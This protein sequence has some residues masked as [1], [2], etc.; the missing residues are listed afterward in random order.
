[1]VRA[2]RRAGMRG[3]VSARRVFEAAQAG[4]ERAAAVVAVEAELIA[5]AVCAIITVIDPALVVLSGGIGQAPAAP[6]TVL[7]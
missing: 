2:A 5:R 6:A 1:M 3:P 4:E 7:G